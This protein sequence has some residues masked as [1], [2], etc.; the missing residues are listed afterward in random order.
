MQAESR[1]GRIDRREVWETVHELAVAYGLERLP[2][3]VL[4]YGRQVA[5]GMLR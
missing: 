3:D 5:V 2:A 4:A 1:G